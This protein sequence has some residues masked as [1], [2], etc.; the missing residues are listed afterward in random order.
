MAIPTHWWHYLLYNQRAAL[1]KASLY[2]DKR[3]KGS[4]RIVVDVL[5]HLWH[6]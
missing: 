1:L 6:S 5:Y 2:Y 3:L 4:T